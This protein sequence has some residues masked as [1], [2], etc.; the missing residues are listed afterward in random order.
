MSQVPDAR[1]PG[2]SYRI[3]SIRRPENCDSATRNDAISRPVLQ[4][5]LTVQVPQSSVGI[6][7]SRLRKIKEDNSNIS[8]LV[9]NGMDLQTALQS[10]Y[11]HTKNLEVQ[12]TYPADC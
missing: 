8:Q 6:V 3:I 4:K 5:P 12:E 9:C 11:Q 7:D 1:I 2:C 10:M